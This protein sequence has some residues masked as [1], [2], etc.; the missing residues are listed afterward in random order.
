[1]R[2][3]II[4][5][6]TTEPVP[7]GSAIVVEFDP[8]S[9]WYAASITIAAS[10]L[11][12]GGK[13][14]FTVTNQP[15]ENVRL[16][17]R[18]LGL[19]P[20]DFEAKGRL[21]LSDWYTATLGM[22]SKEKYSVDSLKVADLSIMF[23]RQMMRLG[24]E[25]DALVIVDNG[26]VLDRFNEERAW[27]EFVLSRAIATDRM[28]K[29]TDIGGIVRGVHSDWVYKTI[30]AAADGIVDLKLDETSGERVNMISIRTMRN[31][32]FDP[33][34]HRLKVDQN[35]RVGLTK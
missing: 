24:P 7:P 20:E 17:L 23:S 25:P 32:G 30:E 6:L 31:V 26:S 28:R 34:W 9:L 10:W 18:R 35:F 4:E 21:I 29:T 2:T 15:P 19:D 27:V 12:S 1:M 14:Y 22:K 16:Q 33:G 13:V 11:S 3:P 8:A 5:E